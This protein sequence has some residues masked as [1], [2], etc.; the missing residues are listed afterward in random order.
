MMVRTGWLATVAALAMMTATSAGAQRFSEG[1]RYLEAV[2]KADGTEL[3]KILNNPQSRI[4]DARNDAGEGALHIV[5]KRSDPTYLGFLLARGANPNIQDGQ[6]ETPLMTALQASFLTGVET[7]IARK[8]NVNLANNRGETPLIRA[9]QLRNL[10]AARVLLAA[11]ANP[12]QTDNVAGMSARDY[13]RVDTRSPALSKLLA[14]AA[15]V[16]ARRPAAGPKLR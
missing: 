14:D 10:E 3:T 15:K 5:T 8:A 16:E 6:G 13:A 7:L 1:Y 4:I 9:V 2:K 12:D 11:G